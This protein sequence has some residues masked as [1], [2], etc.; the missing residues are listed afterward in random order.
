M[1][2]SLR[3]DGWTAWSEHVDEF[4]GLRTQIEG[5]VYGTIVAKREAV[6]AE[7][8]RLAAAPDRVQ[9]LVGWHWIRQSVTGVHRSDMALQ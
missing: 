5:H 3:S 4:I 6:E 2:A 9:S 7:L 1:P 8:E